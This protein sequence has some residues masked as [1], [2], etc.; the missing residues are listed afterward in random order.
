VAAG[1]GGESEAGGPR[2]RRTATGGPAGF[3][4][5]PSRLLKYGYQEVNPGKPGID[6]VTRTLDGE[7]GIAVETPIAQKT[8][9]GVIGTLRIE[10]RSWK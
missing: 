9:P 2:A 7:A 5:L 4:A 8:R 6:A 3:D 10:A 1:L